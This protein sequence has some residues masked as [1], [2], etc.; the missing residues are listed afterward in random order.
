MLVSVI[1]ATC[2]GHEVIGKTL[3]SLSDAS[4]GAGV[5]LEIVVVDQSFDT[6]TFEAIQKWSDL[7]NIRYV[8][9]LK[10]GL[11]HSRNLGLS[12]ASGS[13]V[14]FGDDDCTYDSDVFAHVKQVLGEGRYDFVSG[15][16]YDP[17]SGQLTRYTRFPIETDLDYSKLPGRITSISLF[18]RISGISRDLRF[19]E[20]LGLGAEFES[21]EEIDYA[22]RLLKSGA[23]ARYIP[24]LKVFHDDPIHYGPKD[25][26]LRG[27][28]RSNHKKIL[29]KRRA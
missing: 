5:D 27:W 18:V 2:D 10:Q 22:V 19:D 26:A 16:V 23:T 24:S 13:I 15:G 1:I 8:H 7:L 3:M 4:P 29:S 20:R 28:A 17:I 11:S 6:R 9:A 25:S 21:C 12:I 14:C